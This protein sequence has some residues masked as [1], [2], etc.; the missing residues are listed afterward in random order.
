MG[1][2]KPYICPQCG[3]QINRATHVCEYCGTKFQQ[4]Y[5]DY[6][7]RFV[8]ER[9]GTQVLRAARIIDHDFAEHMGP[10][11]VS[12]YAVKDIARQ[13]ASCLAPYMDVK[14]E[15]DPRMR[16]TRITGTV[17]VLDPQFRF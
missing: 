1:D 11:E 10:E 14:T 9:P 17:R 13:L 4:E 7:P 12:A 16:Q 15:T 6:V 3:G 5:A 2:L 8:I